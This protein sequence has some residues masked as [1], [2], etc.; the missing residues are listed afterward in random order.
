VQNENVIARFARLSRAGPDTVALP[1]RRGAAPGGRPAAGTAPGP[2]VY[3]GPTRNRK[4]RNPL[5]A[6][7]VSSG[8]RVAV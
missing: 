6:P 7:A 8:T 5:P 3:P 4:R 2:C 1:R